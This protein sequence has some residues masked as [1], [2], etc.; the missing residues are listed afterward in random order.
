MYEVMFIIV[1]ALNL[2][3]PAFIG[4]RAKNTADW[5]SL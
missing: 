1:F 5:H 2:F 3:V 4:M